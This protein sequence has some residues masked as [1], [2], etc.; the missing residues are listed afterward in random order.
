M[1][2]SEREGGASEGDVSITPL[3]RLLDRYLATSGESERAF[4]RRIDLS[5]STLRSVVDRS[6]TL[7]PQ[8]A[9]L[10][11]LADGMGVSLAAVVQAVEEGRGLG[12]DVRVISARNSDLDVIT[13][14]MEVDREAVLEAARR[15]IAERGN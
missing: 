7:S 3:R 13:R 2:V 10:R 15:V 12:E 8:A 11:A 1:D 6:A 14:A 4:A 5:Q 9:N